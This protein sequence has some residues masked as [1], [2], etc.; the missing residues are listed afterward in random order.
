VSNIVRASVPP[1][2][3]YPGFYPPYAARVHKVDRCFGRFVDDL[4]R[5]GLY[6]HSIVVLTAD[7]GEMLGEDGRWGHAYFMYP[8]ILTVPLIVHL[9]A[10]LRS[11]TVDLGAISFLTDVTPTLYASLGYHPKGSNPLMGEPLLGPDAFDPAA[12]RRGVYVLAASYSAVYAVVRRNGH[13]VYIADAVKGE[14]YAYDRDTSGVW[15]A[16]NVSEGRRSVEQRVIRE[17][18]DQ[19]DRVYNIAQ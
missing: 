1:G 9:P 19:I 12:R 11:Q 7:H 3:A 15:R 10:D 5:R 4:K 18:L 8:P 14:D 16:V 13:R 6:D 2:E 17:H